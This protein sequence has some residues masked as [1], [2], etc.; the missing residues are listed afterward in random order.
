MIS[1]LVP[2]RPGCP[3]REAAWAFLRPRWEELGEVLVGECTG[4]WSK[5]EAIADAL[6]R[7]AG[8]VIIVPDAD[9]WCD[10]AA[11][12]AAL[13]EAA[14]AVP[15][16]RVHRLSPESTGL[17]LAGADWRGLPLD[18]SNLRDR[19]PYTGQQAGGIVVLRREV[20]EETPMDRRFGGWGGDDV[21]WDAALCTFH[22][23]PWRGVDDLV[24]L[25]HPSQPRISRSVGSEA[26]VQLMRRYLAAAGKPNR[27]RD[28][29]AEVTT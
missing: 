7:S 14:W 5:G 28:L 2:W 20:I 24:H 4:T 18:R 26:N 23:R 22:G 25:W 12:I 11:A 29:M 15:H 21:A 17:V 16:R 19:K 6:A 27:M 10:P 8:D 9:V 13:E 1:V 3:H